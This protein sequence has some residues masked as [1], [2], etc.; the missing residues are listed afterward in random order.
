MIVTPTSRPEFCALIPAGATM[1]EIGPYAKPVY[2]R[3]Q[4]NVYYADMYSIEQIKQNVSLF[5][6]ANINELPDT[7]HIVMDPAARPTFL[8]D[9]KVDYIFSSHNIEHI[10]DI[11]NHLQEVASLAA[12]KNTKYHLAIPDKRYC[13]DHW[14]ALT[15]FPKMIHAYR[16]QAVKNTYQSV[17][18]NTVFMSHNESGI[19][20]RGEHGD[21]PFVYPAPD[22]FIQKIRDCMAKADAVN[23]EYVDAHN[24][25]FVPASFFYN[26]D[27]LTKLNLIPWKVTRVY[28][29]A[30]GSNEFFAILELR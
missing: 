21:D 28:E 29:T 12:S 16:N 1:L 2:R 7:I 26:I 19:H 4:H 27:I 24:W 13:F 6:H 5:G 18:E 15:H 22:S 9:L 10:P 20:W 3:P 11:I 23:T 17:L 30:R 25:R 14:Q 8:S